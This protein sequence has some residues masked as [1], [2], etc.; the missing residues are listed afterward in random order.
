SLPLTSAVPVPRIDSPDRRSSHDRGQQ[1]VELDARLEQDRVRLLTRRDAAKALEHLVAGALRCADRGPESL[2]PDRV[3]TE[4]AVGPGEEPVERMGQNERGVVE[5]DEAVETPE[6]LIRPGQVDIGAAPARLAAVAVG[7][8]PAA[9]PGCLDRG[10]PAMPGHAPDAAWDDGPD[11][12]E[13]RPEEVNGPPARRAADVRPVI[14]LEERAADDRR[15]R[16]SEV[17]VSERHG[18]HEP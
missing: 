15:E 8:A 14:R 4:P 16:E 6:R 11:G 1:H 9:R 18:G 12:V 10:P 3:A 5:V 7:H 13:G 2:V 17:D